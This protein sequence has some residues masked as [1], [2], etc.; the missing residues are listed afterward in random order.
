MAKYIVS[1][2]ETS[3]GSAIIEANSREEAEEKIM[4]VFYDG[5]V[6]W[7]DSEI[8]G[9]QAVVFEDSL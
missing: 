6:H 9:I 7:M 3:S 8:S 2:T 4:D 1:I 5:G